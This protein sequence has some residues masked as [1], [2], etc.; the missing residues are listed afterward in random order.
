M[1]TSQFGRAIIRARALFFGGLTWG[2][3]TT[4]VNGVEP[5]LDYTV[6]DG[7]NLVDTTESGH[8]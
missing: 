4:Q 8:R 1:K 2:T 6:A 5:I 7:I 3:Q